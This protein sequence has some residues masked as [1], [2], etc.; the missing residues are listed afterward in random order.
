MIK[1]TSHESHYPLSN[2]ASKVLYSMLQ[3]CAS[4]LIRIADQG[5]LPTRISETNEV[6]DN[7]CQSLSTVKTSQV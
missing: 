6:I 7:D 3:I 4:D 2:N 5:G 1:L